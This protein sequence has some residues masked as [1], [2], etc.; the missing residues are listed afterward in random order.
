LAKIKITSV[1]DFHLQQRRKNL[2]RGR[3]KE[4]RYRAIEDIF[5]VIKSNPGLLGNIIDIS[6]QGLSFYCIANEKFYE[7]TFEIDLFFSKKGYLTK[8]ISCKKIFER[9]E[10]SQTP[11]S[12][13]MMRRIGV[14]FIRLSTNQHKQVTHFISHLTTG[15]VT[16]RRC[17]LDRRSN[18]ASIVGSRQS[19]LNYNEF[20]D[21]K[22]RRHNAERRYPIPLKVGSSYRN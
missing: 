20:H 19:K 5:A 6:N 9:I 11:F 21:I 7:D 18:K 4:A 16:D 10:H 22:D 8:K 3:R 2:T 1:N 17:G 14:S 15:Q 13:L 12:S